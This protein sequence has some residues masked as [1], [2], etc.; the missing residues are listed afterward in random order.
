M[1]MLSL[2]IPS[3]LSNW[4]MLCK[5][6]FGEESPATQLIKDKMA[7]QGEEQEVVADEGQLLMILGQMHLQQKA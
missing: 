2:G 6:T 5:A 3:T 4:L 1:K 7:E